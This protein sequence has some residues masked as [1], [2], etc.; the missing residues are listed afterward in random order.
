MMGVGE[1]G[2]ANPCTQLAS[3]RAA[4]RTVHRRGDE[5]DVIRADLGEIHAI[6]LER[7]RQLGRPGINAFVH[8][9]GGP[10]NPPGR[11]PPA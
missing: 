6:H 5:A 7:A 8:L 3:E 2:G 10:V 9:P 1:G 11:A 4:S